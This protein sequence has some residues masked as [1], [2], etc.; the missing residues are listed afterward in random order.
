MQTNQVEL[1]YL[2]FI[3]RHDFPRAKYNYDLTGIINSN[4]FLN[5][6]YSQ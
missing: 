3:E 1:L 4:L 2:S 5:F 6:D